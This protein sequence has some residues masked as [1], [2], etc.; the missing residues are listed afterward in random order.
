MSLLF[1]PFDLAGLRLE[2]RVVMAPMTRARALRNV[3]DDLTALYYRQRAGAGLIVSEG[4]PVSQEGCGYLYTPGLYTTRQRDGWRKVT[5]AVHG[6]G[7]RIFAQLWHVGRV[8]HSSL[9]PGGAPPVG[10]TTRRAETTNVFAFDLE[11]RPG[12]VP[13]SAPRALETAE[14]AGVTLDFVRAAR[15]AIDAGFDGI[16][17]HG[18]NGYIFEQFINGALNDRTDRYGGSIANRLRFLLETLDAVSAEIG[19]TRV[20]VRIS[21]FGRLNDLQPYADEVETWVAAAAEL[22][23]RRPA[24]VHL[25]DQLTIGAEKLPDGFAHSFCQTYRGTLIA[26]GGFDRTSGERALDAGELDLVAIGRDFIANPDL[27]ERMYHGWPLAKADRS[28]LY[29]MTGARG[30]T[31]YPT[32]AQQRALATTE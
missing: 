6:A 29:G 24:Y 21:P 7:G 27:V 14:I 1:E 26:A 20:G 18:A 2:N 19:S 10:P 13:A 8:S 12:T 4:S 11:G 31:D 9:Q 22:D 30:Y 23:A 15:L 32:W 17:I 16:E 5:D 28:T 3:P 25:S